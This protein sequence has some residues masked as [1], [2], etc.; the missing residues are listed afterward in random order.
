MDEP[1]TSDGAGARDGAYMDAGGRFRGYN[2]LSDKGE[3]HI[4]TSRHVEKFKGKKQGDI[5]RASKIASPSFPML[6][7]WGCGDGY[8]RVSHT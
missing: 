6:G 5:A 7:G 2:H 3:L 8:I 4:R 1:A